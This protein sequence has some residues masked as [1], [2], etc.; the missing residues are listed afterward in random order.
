M[1]GSKKK[2]K[3]NFEVYSSLICTDLGGWESSANIN[4]R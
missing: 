4:I 1:K 2:I 3:G